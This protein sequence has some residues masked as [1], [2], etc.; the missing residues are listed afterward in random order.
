MSRWLAIVG[1]GDDGLAGL[2]DAARRL[3]EQA[4]VLVGGARHLAMLPADQRERLTLTTP[5][6][7]L[8]E[9]ILQRR[10]RRVCVLATGDPM[11]H[12]I[13]VTLA[14]HV[15]LTEML[16]LPA[17]SAYSLAAARLGWPLA[18]VDAITLHGR[19]LD[20]LSAYLQPGRRILA[21]SENAA[22]PAQ[23]AALLCRRGY[24]ASRI[25]V[26]SHM[27][28]GKERTVRGTA[29]SW[30]A[31]GID[32]LNTVAIECLADP[33]TKLLALVPGL[34]DDAFRHD[35]Q[36]TKRE[37]RA[38]TLA[39]LAPV[40]GQLLWDVGAGA[41]SIAIEWLRAHRDCC[42]I[43][44][45]QHAGRLDMIAENAAVLGVPKLKIVAGKAPAA[46]MGLEAPDTIFIGG[47]ATSAGLFEVCWSALKPG[48][49]LVA[50][51]VTLESEALLFRWRDQVG[52]A[53]SRLSIE[54]AT[55]IG[56]FTAWHPFRPVVQFQATK[57]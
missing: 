43:A 33:G 27:G 29:A 44:I 30:S 48:G 34:P 55:G 53:L 47:G 50:N 51:A 49:R 19:P 35:G 21:L 57:P 22:T 18:E 40:P 14:K 28:S 45:E 38:V 1:I 32:D 52:G 7:K 12:G 36:L 13:G 17:P 24:G 42:A 6:G 26:L 23:V 39:A 10:G 5:L 16:M 9:D 46:L 54:R 25:I 3:V 41:G 37:V 11:W 4:E 15:P 56:G 20:V 8:V 2:N 31:D